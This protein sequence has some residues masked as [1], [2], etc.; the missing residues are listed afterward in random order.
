MTGWAYYTP[1]NVNVKRTNVTK[2]CFSNT[3]HARPLNIVFTQHPVILFSRINESQQRKQHSVTVF[4]SYG[5]VSWDPF[6]S[7]SYSFC[8]CQDEACVIITKGQKSND[9]R[10][11]DDAISTFVF[12][13]Y[14]T[15]LVAS[16][17]QTTC[18]CASLWACVLVLLSLYTEY[19]SVCGQRRMLES[20]CGSPSLLPR[21]YN[22]VTLSVFCGFMNDC[23]FHSF[24][25]M[26]VFHPHPPLPS[27]HFPSRS[28]SLAL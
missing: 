5:A 28:P 2:T 1:T 25:W 6:T 10:H 12:P 18:R 4:I 17:C 11:F 22:T 21:S 20:M 7:V 26:C 14:G 19:V 27:T 16:A 9:R 3:L 15:K 8:R 23:T 13:S 24:M